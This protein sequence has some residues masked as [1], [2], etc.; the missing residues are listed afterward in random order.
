MSL[1]SS[2]VS[3]RFGMVGCGVCK[4][5]QAELCGRGILGNLEQRWTDSRVDH[6][7]LFHDVALGADLARQV[8]PSRRIARH[9][10]SSRVAARYPHC[11]DEPRCRI[12]VIRSRHRHTVMVHY[13]S[14]LHWFIYCRRA[15]AS[16]APAITSVQV[17]TCFA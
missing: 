5:A 14:V 15:S 17:H 2:G 6:L 9:I 8:G 11:A 10:L 12:R 3:I 7:I 13:A 16:T 4:G 1:V